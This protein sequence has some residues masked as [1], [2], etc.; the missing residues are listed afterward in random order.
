LLYLLP[1]AALAEPAMEK[2]NPFLFYQLGSALGAIK[3][4]KDA[5]P[6]QQGTPMLDAHIVLMIAESNLESLLKD[7]KLKLRASIRKA[8]DTLLSFVKVNRIY[9]LEEA[10]NLDT[11]DGLRVSAL[12]GSLA[13][14]EH[15]LMAELPMLDLYLVGQKG[16]F[17]TAKLID[18]GEALFPPDLATKIPGAVADVKQG[19]RCLAFELPT[20]AG[21]HFHRANEAVLRRYWDVMTSGSPPPPNR[22]AGQYL[23]QME[24][25]GVGDPIVISSLRDLVKLRRNPLAHPDESLKD[26]NEAIGV[27]NAIHTLVVEMLK[28]IP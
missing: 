17:D 16:A 10:S 13:A 26:V 1:N 21:Y 19:A 12:K 8:A 11:L 9:T 15:I 27:V 28:K 7:E 14:L 20:A 3:Q 24:Q 2:I 5:L 4:L 25:K 22:A 18:E 23:T 6:G